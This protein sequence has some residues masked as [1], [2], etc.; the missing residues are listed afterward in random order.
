[1]VKKVFYILTLSLFFLPELHSQWESLGLENEALTKIII[2]PNDSNT[3]FAGSRSDFS[4][5]SVGALFKSTN[6]GSTWD[7]LLS[8]VTVRDIAIHPANHNIIYIAAGANAGNDPGVLKT[9]DGGNNWFNADSGISL[10]WETNVGSIRIDPEDETILYCGTHGFG[11]GNLY[12]TT[13]GGFGWFIPGNDSIFGNGVWLIEFDSY[14]PGI[15]YVG[16]SFE[17]DLFKG[18][19]DGIYWEFVGLTDWGGIE[20][21]AFGRNSYEMYA[22]TSWSN[23]YPVG[24]FKSTDK[25]TTWINLYQG[26]SGRVN[27]QDVKVRYDSSEEIYMGA[28]AEYEEIGAY[29]KLNNHPWEFFGL[30]GLIINSIAINQKSIFAATEAGLYYRDLPVRV[31][32]EENNVN[33]P[34]S[35]LNPA[36]PNPFNPNTIISFSIGTRCIVTL[37]IYDILGKKVRTLINEEKPAGSYQIKFDGGDLSSGVYFYQ[38]QA[39]DYSKIRKMILLK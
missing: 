35:F 9:T 6:S 4:L 12:K 16:R 8:I 2:D 1:M 37:H 32:Y 30:A 7:T 14:D 34:L 11:G 13:N 21:L 29:L 26:F 10:D 31:E 24:I 3:L 17:G 38:L 27:V 5:G 15:L 36:Y 18:T 23:D 25:G 39:A 33:V 28:E 20:A 19:G 22:A